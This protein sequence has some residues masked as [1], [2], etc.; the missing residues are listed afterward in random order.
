MR[1]V[2]ITFVAGVFYTVL[3]IILGTYIGSVITVKNVNE[4]VLRQCK[5]GE[6][7]FFDGVGIHC[8]TVQDNRKG[9]SK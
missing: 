8:P 4:E 1:D 6:F 9:E 5:A 2:V 7:Y 3:G